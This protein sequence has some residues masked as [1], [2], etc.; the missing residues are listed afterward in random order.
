M[1]SFFSNTF[2]KVWMLLPEP[3]G[4]TFKLA[5][6]TCVH[7][8]LSACPGAL[9]PISDATARPAV[10]AAKRL[11]FSSQAKI[12]NGVIGTKLPGQG[13]G[14]DTIPHYSTRNATGQ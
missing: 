2:A 4:S 10:A 12:E 9:L 5:P 8:G 6:S 13:L 1:I 14:Q 11:G 3:S 7:P